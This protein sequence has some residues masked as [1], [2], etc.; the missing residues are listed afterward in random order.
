MK[1]EQKNASK[2]IKHLVY[3]AAAI[4][5]ATV[6]S[7]IK[8]FRLP[9]G[10][11]ITFFS[12]LPITLIGYFYGLGAGLVSGLAYGLI[13][14]VL[15]PFFLTPVQVIIDYPLAF[16]ALGLSGIFR[17]KKHGLTE[18]Y[19]TGILARFFFSAVSGLIFF[20]SY[21]T[22]GLSG[23]AYTLIYNGSYIIPEAIITIVIINL[24]PVKK[25]I[26]SIKNA[27]D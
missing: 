1:A 24:P 25:A 16:A 14:F 5:L 21:A 17:Q 19:I 20:T 13:Q 7:Y 2:R 12:M 18:G 23:I 4:S 10:G 15:D 27:A 9:M 22:D 3:S 11:S 8:I 26:L 6:L